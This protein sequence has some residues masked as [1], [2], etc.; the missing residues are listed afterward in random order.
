MYTIHKARAGIQ[1][2]GQKCIGRS[3]EVN[4]LAASINNLCWSFTDSITTYAN[5]APLHSWYLIQVRAR[6]QT[7]SSSERQCYSVHRLHTSCL[8]KHRMWQWAAQPPVPS[9]LAVSLSSWILIAHSHDFMNFDWLL[10]DFMNFDWPLSDWGVCSVRRCQ[11]VVVGF[12]P[13]NMEH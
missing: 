5:Q 10:C 8:I 9:R 7:D 4:I 12:V 6:G 1:V 3:R 11:K 2:N 13:W